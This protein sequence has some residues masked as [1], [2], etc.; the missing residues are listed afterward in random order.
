ML[1]MRSFLVWVC[2]HSVFLSCNHAKPTGTAPLDTTNEKA[3][4]LATL[5]SLN[6]AAA[7]ADYTGYFHFYSEGAIFAG[8]D[9]TERWD[10]KEFMVWAKPFF[11]QGKAWHFTAIE[12]HIYLNKT[13]DLAWFD[14]LLNTQMKI[15]RGSGVLLKQGNSWKI[16]QYILSA[17][18]P[19]EL[20]DKVTIMKA[21]VEDSLI[22]I[23]SGK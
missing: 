9:A 13:G 14:E 1:K 5:D 12:R 4:I 3:T 10:K 8:T 23:K 20:I 17:T 7:K 2:L 15:C 16:Q 21:P 18:V 22:K 6:Q 19:N 11:D